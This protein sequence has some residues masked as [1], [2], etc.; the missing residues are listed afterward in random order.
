MDARNRHLTLVTPAA[1]EPH[2]GRDQPGAGA[3]A[4]DRLP[5][6]QDLVVSGQ[7][8]HCS[9]TIRTRGTT[10][11]EL[12]V[13][14]LDQQPVAAKAL[15]GTTARQA[16]LN[17]QRANDHLPRLRLGLQRSDKRRSLRERFLHPRGQRPVPRHLPDGELGTSEVRD[18]RLLDCVPADRGGAQL[19]R[20]GWLGSLGLRLSAPGPTRYW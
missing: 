11:F 10:D 12:V 9:Y 20:G 13:P 18:D 3:E 2:S 4:R 5:P 6:P 19:L 15:G 8:G 17:L 1:P 16:E 7:S 14:H